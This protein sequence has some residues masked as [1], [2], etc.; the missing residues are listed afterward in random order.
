[1]STTT[2]RAGTGRIAGRSDRGRSP[3]T[4]GTRAAGIAVA[5][6]GLAI[7]LTGCLGTVAP[8]LL[9][10]SGG[11]HSSSAPEVVDTS[12]VQYYGACGNEMLFLDDTTYY[13]IP[14]EELDRLDLSPYLAELDDV[15]HGAEPSRSA[16]TARSGGGGAGAPMM[17]VGATST[18]VPMVAPPGPG[19]DQGW[20]TEFSDGMAHIRTDSG[21][22]HWLSTEVR[23][24]GWVC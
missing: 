24:F 8:Q 4:R 20:L 9:P 22:E 21:I 17:S 2:T 6:A 5:V 10:P 13:P 11:S 3:L 7:G 18:R 19:D 23:E 1:M 16:G 14:D 15:P 12:R